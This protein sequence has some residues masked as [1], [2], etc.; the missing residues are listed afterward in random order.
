MFSCVFLCLRVCVCWLVARFVGLLVHYVLVCDW[1]VGH[2][3]WIV[4]S[5]ARVL[6]GCLLVWVCSCV[7]SSVCI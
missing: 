5:L 7:R 3:D 4:C 1:L 6:V 2:V